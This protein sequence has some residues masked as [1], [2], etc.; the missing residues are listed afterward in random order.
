MPVT[1]GG[2]WS[3]FRAG[4]WVDGLAW[5]EAVR[6]G[7]HVGKC[8]TCGQA[9]L[10]GAPYKVRLRDAYPATCIGPVRHDLIGFGPRPERPVRPDGRRRR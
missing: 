3:R 4:Q 2:I 1:G 8:R 6:T 9:L 10:P 7:Q 5:R